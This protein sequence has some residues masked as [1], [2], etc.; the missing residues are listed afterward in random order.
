MPE[1]PEVETI[2]RGLKKRL[3][4]CEISYLEIFRPGILGN[5]KPDQ[6]CRWLKGQT[7]NNIRRR[8]K[9][10][11]F[12]IGQAHLLTHLRMTGK[13]L[14]FDSDEYKELTH[15][16]LVVHLSNKSHLVYHDVRCL[17]SINFYPPKILV[18]PLKRLG[19]EPLS[20]EF[21]PAVLSEILSKT[22][23]EIKPVL[24]DQQKVA[25]IGNI[26]ASEIL[27]QSRIHPAKRADRLKSREIASLYKAIV[28][29][30]RR[31]IDL[32]GTSFSDYRDI[33]NNRGRFQDFLCVY[34]RAGQP[35][36]DCGG[37]IKK[38][39]QGGRSTFFCSNCQ[40]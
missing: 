9:F 36:R 29:V 19:P 2:V 17:G 5:L 15:V 20:E 3:E 22:G 40:Y 35:C 23:R 14:L 7:I 8:G 39:N 30:L 37:P 28:D 1:L 21:S 12:Q 34:Q 6:L 32:H 18:T 13:Y 4:G 33:E 24:L 10:I 27:Y 31:S 26:Y 38:L 11:I 25:G 16:R